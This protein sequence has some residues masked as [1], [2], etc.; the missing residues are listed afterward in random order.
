MRGVREVSGKTVRGEALWGTLASSADTPRLPADVQ[1]VC[2]VASPDR[3]V[4]D[5]SRCPHRGYLGA[6]LDTLPAAY[7]RWPE[8]SG[9]SA[10][11]LRCSE[12]R[13]TSDGWTRTRQVV[14]S[15]SSM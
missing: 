10:R 3:F 6:A 15:S 4:T 11:A 7:D 8:S 5:I 2:V 13:G 12:A 1:M 14:W 9:S